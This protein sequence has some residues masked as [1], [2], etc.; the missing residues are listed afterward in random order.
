MPQHDGVLPV[1]AQ[2]HEQ[3]RHEEICTYTYTMCKQCTLCIHVKCVNS[4][5]IHCFSCSDSYM[6]VDVYT[7]VFII[8]VTHK[9]VHVH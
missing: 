1:P 5:Y 9:Y 8:I 6:H 2:V 3:V 7:H 4:V